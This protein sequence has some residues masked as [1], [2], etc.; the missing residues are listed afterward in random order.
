MTLPSVTMLLVL[1][2]RHLVA[3][4]PMV[5]AKELDAAWRTDETMELIHALEHQAYPG[6]HD[7]SIIQWI[8][9]GATQRDMLRFGGKKATTDWLVMPH[10]EGEAWNSV[11]LAG[12]MS[13]VLEEARDKKTWGF[14]TMVGLAC[15]REAWLNL[16]V[17]A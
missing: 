16:P 6:D 9:K 8:D 11:T 14:S 12:L 17:P 13:T 10:Q 5:T 7:L 2:Y 3:K 1:D 4:D 15:R